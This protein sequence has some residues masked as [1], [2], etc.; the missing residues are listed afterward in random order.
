MSK[1][2]L[3]IT[4][5]SL[6]IK[7][8][9]NALAF[10]LWVFLLSVFIGIPL[11]IAQQ[12]TTTF[13]LQDSIV[14]AQENSKSIKMAQ[15]NVNLV[16][17]KVNE[18]ISAMLP[19]LSGSGSYSYF[20]KP[21]VILD[22]ETISKMQEALAS[23]FPAMP[24]GT[25]TGTP[26]TPPPTAGPAETQSVEVD[27][28]NIRAS[29]TLQQ[30]L[31]TWGKL[32]NN[33]K[34][35]QLNLEAARQGL[36]N[37]KQQLT[38]DVT[39]AFCGILL[40]Q[41]F[42]KV[43]EEA[44]QQVEKH[45]K[46][47]NDLKSAGVST[48]YEVLRASVQLANT[49]SGLIQAQNALRLAK[50][51]FKITLGMDMSA[52]VNI[53]GKFE[54]EQVKKEFEQLVESAIENRPDLKQLKLQ[55]EAGEK[56]VS[57]AKAGNKPNL[58]LVSSYEAYKTGKWEDDMDWSV[59]NQSWNVILAL[60]IPIFDGF[61]TRAQVKQAKSGLN[62]IRLGRE[63]LEDGIWLEVK[64]AYLALQGAQAL[65]D[66]QRETVQQAQEGL[67]IA[68]LQYEN[69][70]ITSIQL[71]DAQL[72][73]TQAEVNRLQALHDY[74]IAIARLEKAIGQKL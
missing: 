47:A 31:F 18:A 41:E 45:L 69:G 70:I 63:Q 26:T 61:A 58:A 25:E 8:K 43:A 68:N 50:E 36:E 13:T 62:Q 7:A 30:P 28:H 42:V 46:T 20:I 66:V 5:P 29:V 19:N 64:S 6:R 1:T 14:F 49:R 4:N 34:Q 39:K 17:A 11:C 23:I 10:N 55:E 71:T 40:A 57:I 53:E 24:T 38:S 54:Y 32:R 33:Y 2:R 35:T 22:E 72:A 21:L 9:T 48:N 56:I 3:Q 52:G 37:A 16:K 67:R 27:K 12:P 44:V 60:N 74:T 73:L 51:G 65:I 15:E 59:T